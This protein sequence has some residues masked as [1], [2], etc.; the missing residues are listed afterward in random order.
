ML[1]TPRRTKEMIMDILLKRILIAG[2]AV[3]GAAV[4]LSPCVSSSFAPQQKSCQDC[5]YSAGDNILSDK[6]VAQDNWQL[7]LSGTD[8]I[9]IPSL[10]PEI[11]A[12][13]KRKGSDAAIVMLTKEAVDLSFTDYIIHAVHSFV[14]FEFV[15]HAIKQIV[16]NDQR[17][18]LIQAIK[19]DQVIMD[20]ITVKDNF[21]YSLACIID[22]SSSQRVLCETIAQTIK[23]D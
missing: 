10:T 16:I 14:G 7:V 6:L 13:F 23:I 2:M 3:I 11:K 5:T 15:P 4:A 20:W 12:V 17:F 9:E 19:E 1:G 8:W 18:I 22:A 21:G